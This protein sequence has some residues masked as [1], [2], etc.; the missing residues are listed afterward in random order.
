[1]S[2]NGT[3]GALTI[4]W[5][6][7]A[8]A[9]APAIVTLPFLLAWR[10]RRG[11]TLGR[12]ES[13]GDRM[14]RYERS[15]EQHVRPNEP[16]VAR[17][18]G[19]GFSKFT[20]S[21]TQPFDRRFTL[22]MV[23]TTQD[24]VA[25]YNAR[26]GYCQSDEITLVF[27][28]TPGKEEG[29]WQPYA[30]NGRVVKIA[31]LLSAYATARFGHHL[32]NIVADPAYGAAVA[33]RSSGRV[34]VLRDAASEKLLTTRL[35]EFIDE[36]HFDGRVFQVPN[37]QEVVNCVFWRNAYDCVRNVVSKVAAFHLGN[38]ACHK[39]STVQKLAML[40]DVPGAAPR[41]LHPAI[42]VGCFVKVEIDVIPFGLPLHTHCG[43]SDGA[44]RHGGGRCSG[45]PGCAQST[46]AVRH[47]GARFGPHD[48]AVV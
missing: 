34:E 42:T 9:V 11:A 25:H 37:I 7:W 4:D 5:W 31:S 17:L 33:V 1:M 41:L 47:A 45:W 38:K 35:A 2:Q 16:I 24:L 40:E 32:R 10:R 19:H 39:K 22:A 46:A 15:F 12:I 21:L 13:L 36:A 30:F 43:V 29:T 28:P 6:W 23:M 20:A 27:A 26:T 8:K 3:V 44:R 18:D 48:A 14:K